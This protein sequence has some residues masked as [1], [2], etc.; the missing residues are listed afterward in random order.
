MFYVCSRLQIHLLYTTNLA[1]IL[2]PS[3]ELVDCG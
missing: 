1:M 3:I 2:L